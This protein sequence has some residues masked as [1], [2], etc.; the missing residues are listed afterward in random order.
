MRRAALSAPPLM[1]LRQAIALA[2]TVGLLA[3]WFMLYKADPYAAWVALVAATVGAAAARFYPSSPGARGEP[4]SAGGFQ[5]GGMD[6]ATAS[7]DVPAAAL[8]E[9][10]MDSMREGVVVIDSAMRV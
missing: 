4:G 7:G 3:A 1:P 9:A 6:G 5:A 8:L 10:T 2:L